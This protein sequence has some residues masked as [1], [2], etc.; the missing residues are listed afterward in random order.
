MQQAITICEGATISAVEVARVEKAMAEL[1]KDHHAPRE[2]T[3]NVT[4]HVHHEFPKTLYKGKETL[5]VAGAEEEAMAEKDGFGHY[6]NEAFTAADSPAPVATAAAAAGSP[7]PTPTLT[8]R[9]FD[10][11][12]G[13]P[14]KSKKS[15]PD[16]EE[17]D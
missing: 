4:L 7:A 1:A 16:L 10:A 15:F 13:A 8:S 9:I 3:L 12:E 6:D 5:S 17:E 2:M 14:K 11:P